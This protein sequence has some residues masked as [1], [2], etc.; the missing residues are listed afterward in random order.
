MYASFKT[1]QMNLHECMNCTERH[2]E[3]LT[4]LRKDMFGNLK[5]MQ[6]NYY[7]RKNCTERHL[8]FFLRLA[9]YHLILSMYP[10]ARIVLLVA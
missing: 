3:M 1:M 9:A 8:T 2:L 6:S 4:H 10:W 5:T 7:G